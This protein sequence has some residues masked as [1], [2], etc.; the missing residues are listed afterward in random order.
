MLNNM[1]ERIKVGKI[2]S[3]VHNSSKVILKNLVSAAHPFTSQGAP[4]SYQLC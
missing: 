1:Q 4:T 3:K 2:L